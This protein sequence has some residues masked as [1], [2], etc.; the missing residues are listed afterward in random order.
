MLN[1]TFSVIFKHCAQELI[2]ILCI[3]SKDGNLVSLREMVRDKISSC[4]PFSLTYLPRIISLVFLYLLSMEY[5]AMRPIVVL[6]VCI[7]Y[8]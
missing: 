2:I 4:I 6:H 7:R 5:A 1:E 8:N 3:S